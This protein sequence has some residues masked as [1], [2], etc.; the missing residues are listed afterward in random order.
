MMSAAAC[1]TI[2]LTLRQKSQRSRAGTET[3][4]RQTFASVCGIC[5]DRA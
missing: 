5:Y 2:A 4:S 3:S 1:N